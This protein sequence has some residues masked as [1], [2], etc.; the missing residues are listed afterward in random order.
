MTNAM[1]TALSPTSTGS[2]WRIVTNAAYWH[3]REKTTYDD[4]VKLGHQH[5]DI[6]R[7]KA[8]PFAINRIRLMSYSAAGVNA[9]I[10]EMLGSAASAPARASD[11][12]QASAPARRCRGVATR[13]LVRQL[14]LEH[15]GRLPAWRLAIQQCRNSAGIVISQASGRLGSA[16]TEP[17][18]APAGRTVNW[19][20]G[21]GCRISTV[22][23]PDG[24]NT[25][26]NQANGRSG[27]S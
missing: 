17:A 8:R 22:A 19:L 15:M 4:Q 13:V 1:G 26:T 20:T 23:A 12:T 24:L 27:R 5:G 9:V 14:Q 11:E 10:A 21:K 2:G 16:L 18:P 7:M 25:S 3:G 6:L